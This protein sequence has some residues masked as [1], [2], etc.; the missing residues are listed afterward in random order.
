M[1]GHRDNEALQ[2]LDHG[3]LGPPNME[4]LMEAA[5]ERAIERVLAPH[6]RRLTA[7]EPT[8]Y[9]VAQVA[10]VLQVSD[11]TVGRLVRRGILPRVPHL[12]GKVLIPRRAVH[13][14]IEGQP[15][16]DSSA[17]AAPASSRSIRSAA[18]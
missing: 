2:L 16:A 11:D 8:V 3:D 9:T 6:L 7:Y 1:A 14:L 10:E 13:R 18:V 4:S 17:D 5:V 15:A 12:E